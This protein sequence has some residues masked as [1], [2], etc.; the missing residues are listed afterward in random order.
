MRDVRDKSRRVLTPL[1]GAL[2]F[3]RAT[4]AIGRE[5]A[6]PQVARREG[7]QAAR[8][9]GR[10]GVDQL[11]AQPDLLPELAVGSW[12]LG[13]WKRRL[14]RRVALFLPILRLLLPGRMVPDVAFWSGV[15]EAATATEWQRLTTSSYVVLCY[16]RIAG[17]VLDGQERMDVDPDAVRRQLRLIRLLGW[18]A[19]S[20]S[21]VL[22]FHLDPTA[23]LPRRCFVLTAD[24]GYAEAVAELSSHTPLHPQVFAVTSAVGGRASWFGDALLATWDELRDFSSTGG[25]VGSHAAHHVPLDTLDEPT[26][27][28]ELA[29]SLAALHTELGI[30]SPPLLAYPH[31]RH[32]ARVREAAR[33]AGYEL[34]YTTAQGR[35]GAG[36]DRLRLRR[37][38]PKIWDSPLSFGWK[39]LTAESPPPWWERRLVGRWGARRQEDT[40]GDQGEG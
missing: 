24:D 26:I 36:T 20:P 29:G 30:H 11:R 22:S 28:E 38:E 39:V 25:I 2:G 34:G 4:E 19:L 32:D 16:H 40:A 21:D 6:A 10:A 37:V 14:V 1:A 15:R 13:G 3:R 17:L 7:V 33:Q 8:A 23:V 27:H 31:G 35:N 9:R 5:E 12:F 18:R